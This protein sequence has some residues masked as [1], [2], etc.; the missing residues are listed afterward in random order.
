MVLR[1]GHCWSCS[2]GTTHKPPR[3]STGGAGAVGSQGAAGQPWTGDQPPRVSAARRARESQRA[4]VRQPPGRDPPRPGTAIGGHGAQSGVDVERRGDRCR[5]RPRRRHCLAVTVAVCGARTRLSEGG[6]REA[7]V[8]KCALRIV[9]LTIGVNDDADRPFAFPALLRSVTRRSS[10]TV[11][12]NRPA[13][14]DSSCDS[15]RKMWVVSVH[16]TL[17]TRTVPTAGAFGDW[18]EHWATSHPTAPNVRG[19]PQVVFPQMTWGRCRFSA[20][21]AGL[22]CGGDDCPAA[23]R[24]CQGE[25]SR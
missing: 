3:V 6:N 10:L 11:G 4:T 9:M 24:P 18:P 1:H 16:R 23:A 19:S 25:T 8:A 5:I 22:I 17:D 13:T 14:R 15:S 2:S 7:I 12:G 20:R 21:S